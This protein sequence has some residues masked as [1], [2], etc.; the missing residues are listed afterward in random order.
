MY[1]D[2]YAV[3][4][5]RIDMY[6]YLYQNCVDACYLYKMV[7]QYMLRTHLEKYVFSDV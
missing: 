4:G 5:N 6:L 7:P 1:C 3:D 2:N